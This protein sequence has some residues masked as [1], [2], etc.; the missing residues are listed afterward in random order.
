MPPMTVILL[1]CGMPPDAGGLR[2]HEKP[3]TRPWMPRAAVAPAGAMTHCG[4]WERDGFRSIQVNVDA[5]GCNI[6]GD[7][8]NEPSLAVDPTDPKKIVIGWRQFDTVASNFRQAGRVIATTAGTLGSFADPSIP[9]SSEATRFLAQDRRGKSITFPSTSTNRVCSG[10][11]TAESP[12]RGAR[13]SPRGWWTS[14]GW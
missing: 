2:Q 6:L 9:G 3:P 12:G 7:A 13:R 5:R 1:F 14:P 10:H 4:P 11:S 8:A